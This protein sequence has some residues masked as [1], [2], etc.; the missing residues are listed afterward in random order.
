M[1]GLREAVNEVMFDA[2]KTKSVSSMNY[3]SAKA[4][5]ETNGS[6]EEDEVINSNQDYLAKKDSK[7]DKFGA[8]PMQSVLEKLLG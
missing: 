3:S 8:R 6:D 7:K 1:S 2:S 5:A 4:N